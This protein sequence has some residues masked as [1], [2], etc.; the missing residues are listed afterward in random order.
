MQV[1]INSSPVIYPTVT[2]AL[3]TYKGPTDPILN[4]H[5]VDKTGYLSAF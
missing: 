4:D 5:A 2:Q 1:M 3:L